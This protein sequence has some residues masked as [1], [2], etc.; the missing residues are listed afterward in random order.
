[1][2]NRTDKFIILK[3]HTSG[4]IDDTVTPAEE[5]I[6]TERYNT[7]IQQAFFNGYKACHGLKHQAVEFPNG[8]CGEL[9]GPKSF[10]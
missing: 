7:L 5:G 10:K 2:R 1:M 8:M 4:F 3:V 6:N 9:Y